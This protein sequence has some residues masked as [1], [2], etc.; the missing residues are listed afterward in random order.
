MRLSGITTDAR[1]VHLLNASSPS[2]VR[3][4][5]NTMDV[6]EVFINAAMPSCVRLSGNTTDVREEQ[7]ANAPLPTDVSLVHPLRWTRRRD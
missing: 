7:P 5:G 1:E 4:S 2:I 6:R 3:L